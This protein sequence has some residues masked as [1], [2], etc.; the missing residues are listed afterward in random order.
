MKTKIIILLFLILTLNCSFKKIDNPI[1]TSS[2]TLYDSIPE[3]ITD[4]SFQ[5]CTLH[6][7]LND[8]IINDNYN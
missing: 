6:V 3:W 5:N 4:T 2:S 8:Y 7:N 1:S